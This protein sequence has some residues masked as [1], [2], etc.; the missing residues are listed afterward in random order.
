MADFYV[1]FG[2][3]YAHIPHPT[4]PNVH[5]DGYVRIT[6]EDELAARTMAYAR[7]DDN[8]A[9]MYT[10]QDFSFEHHPLGELAHYTV[11]GAK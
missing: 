11:P 1:T 6:A 5:P 3:Q 7:W 4:D 2:V 10:E 9:F 8:W